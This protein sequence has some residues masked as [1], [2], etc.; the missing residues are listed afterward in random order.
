[1]RV[2]A[3]ETIRAIRPNPDRAGLV[4]LVTSP[5][6]PSAAHSWVYVSTDC[7]R[8]WAR[9]T[10]YNDRVTDLGWL[11]RANLT[12]LLLATDQGLYEFE[13]DHGR[14]EPPRLDVPTLVP[15]DPG[16]IKAAIHTLA[17]V[18]GQRGQA[19]VAVALKRRGG[20]WLSDGADLVPDGGAPLDPAQVADPT[21][22]RTVFQPIPALEGQDVRHLAT[23]QAGTRSYLWA[24]AMAEGNEALGCY[25]RRVDRAEGRWFNAGWQGGSCRALA[26]DGE[27]AYAATQWGGVLKL[28]LR[29]DALAS[30]WQPST[31]R[32]TEHEPAIPKGFLRFLD[33]QRPD[34]DPDYR[35][36]KPL[37]A[38]G[39]GSSGTVMAGGEA[40]IL[41][42]VAVDDPV[43]LYEES[44][45]TVVS[46]RAYRD[47]ITL[48]YDGL[49]VSG[50]HRVASGGEGE[51]V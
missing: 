34:Y 32:D 19:R 27:W 31:Q 42:R 18:R 44:S 21:R 29:R 11:L 51:E 39:L 46:R 48:P 36:Y 9:V 6:A 30:R 33:D 17:V 43:D 12:I 23:Q 14:R 37:W 40:G 13:L 24:G 26:F 35:P 49:F 45:A 10:D 5:D 3:G 1:M 41:R 20:V 7:G 4:G 28:D 15:V 8:T 16:D 47:R 2:F 38:L 50:I 25:R 22:V